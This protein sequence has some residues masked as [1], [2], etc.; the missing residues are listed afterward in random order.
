MLFKFIDVVTTGRGGGNRCGTKS[1]FKRQ[2]REDVP[3][4]L[5]PEEDEDPAPSPEDAHQNRVSE[6][7]VTRS[8]WGKRTFKPRVGN[9]LAAECLWSFSSCAS[10]TSSKPVI[11][12]SGNRGCE[13][14]F[15][16]HISCMGG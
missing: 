8:A 13:T 3:E 14:M 12:C 11:Y 9:G 2:R 1:D 7:W 5:L 6:A 15:S 10:A 16:L 4:E